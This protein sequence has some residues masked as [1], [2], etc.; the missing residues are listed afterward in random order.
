VGAEKAVMDIWRDRVQQLIPAM[1]VDLI[2]A[3]SD[4]RLDDRAVEHAMS[5]QTQ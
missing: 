5:L 4:S 2:E 3:L 1:V